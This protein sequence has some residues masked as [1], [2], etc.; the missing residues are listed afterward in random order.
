MAEWRAADGTRLGPAAGLARLAAARVALLGERHDSAADHAWQAWVLEA[1][2]GRADGRLA[3][4][5]EAFPR[6]AQGALDAFV[7]GRIDLDGLLAA[8]DWAE[9]WGFDPGLYAGL[10]ALCR[11]RGLPMVALNVDRAV[12]RDVGR[13]G[14]SAL[15]AAERSW[16]SPAAPAAPA[17]R[18]W[19]FAVTGG[20]RP[21][22][23]ARAPEDPA[24]DRFVRA[25]QVWDRAFACAIADWLGRAG[26]AARLVAI[27]GRGHLEGGWGTPAQLADLGTGAVVTALRDAGDGETA[28]PPPDLLWTGPIPAR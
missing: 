23:A 11:D 14:W 24:F 25:Q 20:A 2:A 7:A 9:V 17:Y 10:F 22:R 15:P 13:E 4:G 16:L 26:P 5:F 27:L 8:T 1:L 19:L 12:V 6:R 21:G 3:V 18:R 28:A